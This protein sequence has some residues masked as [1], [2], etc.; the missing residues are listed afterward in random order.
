M[1]W[2][3]LDK[4]TQ[5]ERT[6][7]V[8]AASHPT[9]TALSSTKEFDWSKVVVAPEPSAKTAAKISSPMPA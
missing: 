3:V 7:A 5:K 9:V 1:I 8:Q 2:S 6:V 4:N